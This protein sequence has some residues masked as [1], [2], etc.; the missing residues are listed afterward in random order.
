MADHAG[1]P[2]DAGDHQEITGFRPRAQHLRKLGLQPE[3]SNPAG[4]IENDGD[5][6]R[7]KRKQPKTSNQLLLAKPHRQFIRRKIACQ[8]CQ[9]LATM[10]SI[11][12]DRH[13]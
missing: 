11:A 7:F 10:L 9:D 4:F 6:Q 12:S 1:A 5:R 2:A 8:G 3:R 13:T